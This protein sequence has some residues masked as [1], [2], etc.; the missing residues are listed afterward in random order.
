MPNRVGAKGN[1][2]IDKNIRDRLGV[3]PGWETVQLLQDGYV[4]VYFLPPVGP[5]TVFGRLRVDGA[6][7]WLKDDDRLHEAT[8]RA[9][10]EEVA[11]RC[12]KA[13]TGSTGV[14]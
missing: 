12:W 9:L 10:A 4:E 14:T 2:V 6:S 7:E 3:K 11:E 1:I 8:D 13:W 5:D